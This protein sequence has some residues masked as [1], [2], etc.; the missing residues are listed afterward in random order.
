MTCSQEWSSSILPV[1]IQAVQKAQLSSC[2]QQEISFYDAT[3]RNLTLS[4]PEL[5]WSEAEQRFNTYESCGINAVGIW[6]D[7]LVSKGLSPTI[8]LTKALS[9][10]LTC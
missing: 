2:Y 5:A 9:Y 10:V 1:S 3:T 7:A 4:D 6:K 8:A